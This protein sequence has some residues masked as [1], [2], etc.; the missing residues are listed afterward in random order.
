MAKP[1]S[2]LIRYRILDAKRGFPRRPCRVHA[3][4][5]EIRQLVDDGFI[6]KRRLVSDATVRRLRKALSDVLA[7][8]KAPG[9]GT[10]NT[11]FGSEYLRN[12]ID[13]HTAF[14]TLFRLKATASIARA[15]L[16]PQVRFDEITARITELDTLHASTP[17]HIHLRAVPEPLPPF[18]VYPHAIECLLYLDHADEATGALCV[19]PGS[20]LQLNRI[21][22]VQ[23][24]DPK[25]GQR[26]LSLNPGDCVIIHSN[27][28]HRALPSVATHGLRRLLIFGYQ[29][30]W[31]HG[32]ERGGSALDSNV[33]AQL[34][35]HRDHLVR[36]LAGDFYWG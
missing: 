32:D 35:T 23:D 11:C 2:F 26:T 7:I 24:V 12:L 30:S 27:L 14:A 15:V 10:M 31:L 21:H 4:R 18:F 33:L 20:H 36:E 3:S 28:W 29:P 19:L 1:D 25:P 34:R 5:R 17:W 6:V 22:P 16:G 9:S 13:K 8:E